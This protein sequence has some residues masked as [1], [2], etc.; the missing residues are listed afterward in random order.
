MRRSEPR[1]QMGTRPLRVYPGMYM[2]ISCSFV[3]FLSTVLSPDLSVYCR[4]QLWCGRPTHSDSAVSVRA[5]VWV[6]RGRQATASH[7]PPSTNTHT[8][9]STTNLVCHPFLLLCGIDASPS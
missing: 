4:D 1:V 5:A 2:Q 3:A 9:L 7:C 6:G 8:H